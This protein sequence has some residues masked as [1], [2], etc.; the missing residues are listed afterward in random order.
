MQIER[1]DEQPESALG[2][3]WVS[4]DPDPRENDSSDLHSLKHSA[5]ITL[6]DEG[7]QIDC[8]DEQLQNADEPIWKTV[9]PAS[10]VNDESD[11]EFEKE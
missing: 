4:S 3:N 8:N 1:N 7:R 10:N 2:P 5:G 11:R 9:E 6:T